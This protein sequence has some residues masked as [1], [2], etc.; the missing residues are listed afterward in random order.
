MLALHA[1][2]RVAT[3]TVFAVTG[4]TFATWAARVPAVRARLD[5]SPGE[6][7]IAFLGLAAGAIV[8]LP[9]SGL[10][11]GRWGSRRLARAGL[12]LYCLALLGPALAPTLPLLAAALALFGAGNSAVDVAMSVQGVEAERRYARPIMAGFS[13]LFSFGTLAGAAT[14]TA[15][16]A[17]G[18]TV[19]AHFTA[20]AA[21]LLTL[22]LAATG[23][24]LAEA[25]APPGA[26]RLVLP[27]RG[28]A[29]L[30]A[31]AFAA[32]LAEGVLQDW[33]AVYL[34]EVIGADE[35]VAASG[36][37][38]LVATMTA[39]RLVADRLVLRAGPARFA[40]AGGLVAAAGLL[41]VVVAD[42]AW[43]AIAG[44]ALAGAGLAGQAPTVFSLAGHHAA[45]SAARMPVGQAIAAVSTVGYFGF[46]A[47]PAVVGG[48][49]ELAGLRAAVA[50]VAG[51][52][53]LLA[54]L[55]T[56]LDRRHPALSTTAPGQAPGPR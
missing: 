21:V 56:R 18:L 20:A 41:L 43:L 52:A 2:A 36:F 10:L 3:G 19:L 27:T 24:F 42:R 29:V 23:W 26:R 55:A 30:G 7:G 50:V 35:S 32:F 53:V 31:V 16:T 40:A 25:T 38:V 11:A 13:A 5:L 9:V 1:R 15:A 17:L 37:A 51:V 4:A 28:L 49:A 22:G 8:A 6:L 34:R 33:S 54:L 44:L 39:G 48:V 45:T 46:L 14:A 12:T 47:G